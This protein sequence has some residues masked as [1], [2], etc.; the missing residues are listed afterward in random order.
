MHI[1]TYGKHK[2]PCNTEVIGQGHLVL[3]QHILACVCLITLQKTQCAEVIYSKSTY[4][5]IGSA[6]GHSTAC[7]SGLEEEDGK[8]TEMDWDASV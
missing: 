2:I 6:A 1:C 8:R 5:S 7:M 3:H 4:K